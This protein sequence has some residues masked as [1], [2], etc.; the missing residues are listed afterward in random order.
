MKASYLWL[1]V[2]FAMFQVFWC[3]HFRES[4]ATYITYS[5]V[6][7][8]IAI[9]GGWTLQILRDQARRLRALED[10]LDRLRQRTPAPNWDSGPAN[11]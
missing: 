5:T 8:W 9:L 6:W 11:E 7:V 10:Q 4:P 3:V 2:A 1:P